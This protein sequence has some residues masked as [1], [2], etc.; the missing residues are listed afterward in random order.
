MSLNHCGIGLKIKDSAVK[1]SCYKT[2]P[3]EKTSTK[4][5]SSFN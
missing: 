1:S 4:L 3:V 5:F 2:S